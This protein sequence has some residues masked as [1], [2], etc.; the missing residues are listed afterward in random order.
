MTLLVGSGGEAIELPVG[1][2]RGAPDEV[3]LALLDTLADPVLDV[4]CGPGRIVAALGS[5]GRPALGVDPSPAAV[6]E[7]TRRGAPVLA[8]SVFGSLPGE[9]RWGTVLLLD[10]SIGIGGDPAALLARAC[11]LVRRG[12]EVVAEVEPPGVSTGPMT[13]RLASA[14]GQ[15]AW[16][17]WAR[18]GADGFEP[19]AAAAGLA[20]SFL[21][22]AGERWFAR[23]VRP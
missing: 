3:E 8:R 4:G 22:P 19:L 16:F 15:S 23:A 2:W 17:A 1:R 7:A 18:V 9:G 14:R 11:R 21:Q 12:G 13:A 20:A 5:A 6:A 10:G